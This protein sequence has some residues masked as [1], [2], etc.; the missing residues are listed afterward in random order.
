MTSRTYA[1]IECSLTNSK[2]MR[3]LSEHAARWAYLC[4]H[5][6]DYCTYTG[7][8]RYPAVIW[9]HDAQV[10]PDGLADVTSELSNA[11]LI[12]YDPDEEFIR[13]VGWFYKRS[14]PDNPNRVDSIIADLS[15]LSGVNDQM[16]CNSAA[17]LT[18]ASVKR[19]LR[20]KADSPARE[21]LYQS[22]RTFLNETYQDYGDGFISCL[23]AELSNAPATVSHEISAFF[24][25]LALAAR[26]PSPN[27]SGTLTPILQEHE[28][29]RDEDETKMK[30]NLDENETALS[31]SGFNE[32]SSPLVNLSD[33]QRKQVNP[34][35]AVLQSNLVQATRNT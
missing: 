26:E 25:P 10:N 12:Q 29:R 17:E 2:K 8:F 35:R 6:S 15:A 21:Q 14:G 28:T 27:P 22:L 9:A 4:V 34:T 16:F 5:L 1:Q 31:S 33:M 24:Q 20:W 3:G 32:R 18:C 23:T 7:L 30:L 13:I 19:S 11:G